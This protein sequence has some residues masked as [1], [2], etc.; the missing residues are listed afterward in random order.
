MDKEKKKKKRFS[1]I[2]FHDDIFSSQMYKHLG[3]GTR[4][5]FEIKVILHAAIKNP[6]PGGSPS[7]AYTG[8]PTEIHLTGSTGTN[9]NRLPLPEN[10]SEHTK[11]LLVSD[12]VAL[13]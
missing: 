12:C 8:L 1:G 7:Y 11:K 10:E 3:V 4:R 13:L 5:T 6:F 9:Y 2:S